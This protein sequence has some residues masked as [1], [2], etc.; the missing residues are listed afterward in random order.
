[1]LYEA[2]RGVRER[3][4]PRLNDLEVAQKNLSFRGWR[5]IVR[6]HE[7]RYGGISP[8][9]SSSIALQSK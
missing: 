4:R 3:C 9:P 7:E 5:K 2:P 1:M 6:I 8:G